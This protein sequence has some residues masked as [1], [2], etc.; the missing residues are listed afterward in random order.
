MVR[1][2]TPAP[3]RR[4]P[5]EALRRWHNDFKRRHPF[6]GLRFFSKRSDGGRDVAGRHWPSSLTWS[7]VLTWRW[8]NGGA[9]GSHHTWGFHQHRGNDSGWF[10]FPPLWLYWQEEMPHKPRNYAAQN[11]FIASLLNSSPAADAGTREAERKEGGA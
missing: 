3:Y 2:E 11:R 5:K 4:S 9:S 6:A 10:C 8:P 7:W 1:V